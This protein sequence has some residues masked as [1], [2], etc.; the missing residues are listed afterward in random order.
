MCRVPAYFHL[1]TL[2]QYHR[3]PHRAFVRI[4]C[5]NTRKV[6]GAQE[7]GLASS[8]LNSATSLPPYLVSFATVLKS[9]SCFKCMFVSQSLSQW[10]E[11]GRTER[12]KGEEEE[13]KR[14][15]RRKK[16]KEGRRKGGKEGRKETTN[17]STSNVA[18]S[19]HGAVPPPAT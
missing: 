16:G 14:E 8:A 18:Q 12:K 7:R 1:T 11:G 17:G 10:K 5:D 19:I 3:L 15:G 9:R 6:P 4:N 13:R 2:C